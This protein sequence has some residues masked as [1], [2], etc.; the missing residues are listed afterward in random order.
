[1]S[2][3]SRR[4]SAP[5]FTL[6]EVLVVVATL[7]MILWMVGQLLFPMRQAAERQR[8]E[9]EARQ[10]ARAASDYLGATL[11][12]AG[13]MNRQ[14]LPRDPALLLTF[15]WQGDGT[16]VGSN[17][18]C[19]GS[20]IAGCIQTSYNNVPNNPGNA[21]LATPGTDVITIGRIIDNV[22]VPA[23]TYGGGTDNH[24]DSDQTTYW[25]FN[26]K[27]M[28]DG[29]NLNQ[30]IQLTGSHATAGGTRSLPLMLVD[31]YG[32][33]A[34]YQITDYQA[35]ANGTPCS[36][37][38]ALLCYDSTLGEAVPCIAV[39]AHPGNTAYNAPGG[40]RVLTPTMYLYPGVH[41]TTFRVC[42][43]W[44]EQKNGIFDPT[45]DTNCPA[46]G[47]DA[48]FPATYASYPGS[49][50][51]PG[52]DWS[53]LLPNIE[54]LQFAYMF[55][56]GTVENG[57]TSSL[58]ASPDP[59]RAAPGGVPVM[60]GPATG[61][62][63]DALRVLGVRVTVTARSSTRPMVGAGKIEMRRPA[64]EDHDPA[65]DVPVHP[66]DTYFRSQLS[67]IAMLRNRALGDT[68]Y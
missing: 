48:E 21:T 2:R 56:D 12:A 11:R 9:V 50:T 16:G 5:G 19:D 18:A 7:A 46:L 8:L 24:P 65:N 45:V 63:V 51:W 61:S 26:E 55:A 27:C 58:G 39:T 35:A 32:N 43:G 17:P 37:P 49:G 57:P 64:S 31:S 22:T 14:A 67:V 3:S 59:V 1:M 54:D 40:A 38:S 44:L 20:A 62:S 6:V 42:N 25:K 33:W 13:D 66:T 28:D 10:S 41:Y 52:A 68:G 34:F 23:L 53:P 47:G 29:A 36:N 15:V 60:M 30:F 4:G